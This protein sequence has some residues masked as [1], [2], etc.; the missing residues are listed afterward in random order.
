MKNLA[1]SFEIALRSPRWRWALLIA[2]V[3]DAVGFGLGLIPPIQWFVDAV[4]VL[5]LLRVI[6]FSWPL[7]GALVV[8][9]IPFLEVFPMWTLVVLVMAAT[10][11]PNQPPAIS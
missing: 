4:T 8:E 11:R 5:A 7:L 10:K 9:A 3:S 6:G 1:R 2:I